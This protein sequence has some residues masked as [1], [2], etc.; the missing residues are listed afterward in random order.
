[1]EVGE[2][3]IDR[4]LTPSTGLAAASLLDPDR[5]VGWLDGALDGVEQVGADRVDLD[6]VAQ[7]GGERRDRRLGVVAGAVEAAVDEALD[8]DCAAG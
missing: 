4:A 5:G 7:P 2:L 8:A 6:G 3:W 1:M